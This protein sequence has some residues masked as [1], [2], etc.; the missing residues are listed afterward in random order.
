MFSSRSPAGDCAMRNSFRELLRARIVGFTREPEAVFWTFGF[1]VLIAVA[2]GIAFRNKGPEKI[3]VGVIERPNLECH[4]DERCLAGQ[5]RG[6]LV[7]MLSSDSALSVAVIEEP[8]GKAQLRTGKVSILVAQ[9]NPLEFTLDPT[10][11][12]SRVARLE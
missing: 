1:P 11:P 5:F 3:Y 8:D 10:R 9:R 4:P 7:A 6:D 2:L 12:E